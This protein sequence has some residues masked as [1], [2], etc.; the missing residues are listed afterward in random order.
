MSLMVICHQLRSADNLGAIARL[1]ANFSLSQLVL[2]DP[3]T[4][5]F[6]GAEKLAVG[7]EAVLRDVAVAASLPEALSRCV[8]A[9][10]TTS[11]A[12][13]KCL[14][15]EA[16]MAR[17]FEHAARGPVA[18][19]LGGEKRGL[20]DDEL[21]H[22][23][24]VLAIP[25]SATQPSM[26]ISQA[27]AVLVYLWSRAASGPA[28][29]GAEEGARGQTLQALEARLHAALDAVGWVNKQA[30]QHALR[31]LTRSLV[32]GKLTQRE[33]EMWLSALEHVRRVAAKPATS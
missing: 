21:S 4:H 17:L 7:A 25:T 8:Y 32:Q 16:A 29:A 1:M 26:N 2:S 28:P 10:G 23:H 13:E 3:V 15:P 24:D 11:R 18:L 22:C 14:T 30:P 27:A 20:S 9:V 12:V 19:V 6:R 33:A 31:E 5:D